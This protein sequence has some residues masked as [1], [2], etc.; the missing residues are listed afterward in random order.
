MKC[1][2]C[3]RYTLRKDKCPYC[4]GPLINPHPPKYSPDDKLWTYRLVLKVMSGQIKVS[5][6]VKRRILET[7]VGGGGVGEGSKMLKTGERGQA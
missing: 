1:V 2:N 7:H 4:G 5:D 3:G 6:D